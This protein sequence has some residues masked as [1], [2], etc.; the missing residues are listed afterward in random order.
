MVKGMNAEAMAAITK[1][2]NANLRLGSAQESE[3][4]R[5]TFSAPR[6]VIAQLRMLALELHCSMNDLLLIGID[7]LLRAARKN[8]PMVIKENIRARLNGR[9][10]QT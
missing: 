3:T 2:L 4:M 7:D 5:S 10:E 1:N 8:C 6:Q 9:T